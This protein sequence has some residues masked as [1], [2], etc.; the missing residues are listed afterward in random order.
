QRVVDPGVHVALLAID[1][2]GTTCRAEGNAPL[3]EDIAVNGSIRDG[4]WHRAAR[5]TVAL[6]AT[7][8]MRGSAAARQLANSSSPFARVY[9]AR[10]AA[11]AADTALLYRLAGDG[12]A[13]VRTAST[14]GLAALVG[15]AADS[16]YIAQLE[17]NHSELLMTA[18][19]ALEGSGDTRAAVLL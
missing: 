16:V 10:A 19:A 7:D 8:A 17:S 3:L 14:A 5:A 6:A 15:H 13:N 18:A 4:L 11:V 9:A 12:D 1:L 2:L